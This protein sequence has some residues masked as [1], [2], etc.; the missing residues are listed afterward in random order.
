MAGIPQYAAHVPR[1]DLVRVL[2]KKRCNKTT[3]HRLN[4]GAQDV[5][6]PTE[7]FAGCT[8][9]CLKCSGTAV[10]NYNFTSY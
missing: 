7:R 2:C 5:Q 9:T 1:S 4:R 6:N 8:A 10:D 3:L